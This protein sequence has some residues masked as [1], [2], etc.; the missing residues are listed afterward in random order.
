VTPHTFGL[1]LS[2]EA[3]YFWPQRGVVGR[4]V[5]ASINELPY[6]AKT[7]DASVSVDILEC[8]GVHDR[9]AYAELVRVTRV[10]GLVLVVVPAYRWMMTQGHHQAVHAVRRYN[11]A[12][13]LALTEG[14]SVEVL[15]L[16]HAFASVFPMVAG[17][18]L[19]HRWQEG[20]GTVAIQSELA[21]LPAALNSALSA[22]VGVER[23]ALRVMNMPFGSSLILL[24]RRRA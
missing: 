16:T 2:A 6:A 11:R 17:V 5:L 10:G 3:S 15:R 14:L 8:D 9:Q 7:F 20:R 12:S 1:D 4:A 19:W 21:P 18:R 13:V 23:A 24:A 22:L